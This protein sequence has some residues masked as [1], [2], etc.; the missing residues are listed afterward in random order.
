MDSLRQDARYAL[1]LLAN[2]PGF[3]AIAVLTLALGIGANTAIFSVVNAVLLGSLPYAEPDRLVFVAETTGS[4]PMPVSYPNFL[5]WR[6][7]QSALEKLAAYSADDFNLTGLDQAD[8]V[9]GELVSDDYFELLGVN[10]ILGRTF[11]EEENKTPGAAPVAMISH[12]F[13]QSRFGGDDNVLG[14]SLKLNDADFTIIGVAP[15]GFHGF[16]GIAEVWMPM[17]MRDALYPAT[18]RFGF[19]SARDIHWHRVLGRLSPGVT[20]ARAQSEMETIGARLANDFPQA[21]EGRGV[22]L[23]AA[24]E[25][26]V[27]NLRTPLLVLLAAVA[28]VLLIACTN[29]ANLFLARAAARSREMAIRLALGASRGRVIRQLLTETLIVA[30]LG[31]AA[32]LLLALW[33]VEFLV[34]ILPVSLPRFAT[35]S[36]VSIDPRVLAFTS[37]ISIITGV[38]M[39][40]IPALQAS[41]TGLNEA[42]KESGRSTGGPRRN[43]VRSVLVAAEIAL[44][45]MLMIGAGLMLRSFGR[46]LAVDPGFKPDHLVTLRFDAP[47]KK[48]QGEQRTTL[49]QRLVER[50]EAVPGVE[51][52][53]ATFLD[54]FV[55]GGINLEYT[56]EGRP[57]IDSA[58]RDTVYYHNISPNYFRTMGI[59]LT[60]GRDFTLND[61]LRSPQVMIVSASFARRYW[62]DADPLGMRVKFGPPESTAPWM[63]VAGVA[64]DMKFRTLRQDESAE[65]VIYTPLLQ[66]Q[67]VV[68]ISLIVRTKTEPSGMLATLRREVQAFDADIPIYSIAT[69]EDR[70]RGQTTETRSYALLLSLFGLVAA[71]LAAIGIYGVMAYS[72]A[73]RTH[74]IGVRVALG[75]QPRDVQRLVVGQ[76]MLIAMIGAA[77]GLIGAF[78]L[79]RLMSALLFNISATDP[80]T[81]V[82]I[83]LALVAVAL[84]ACLIPARRATKVDPM[85][86]LR[87]E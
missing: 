25:R 44:A 65:P 14:R 57:R 46:M 76:G 19:L 32:G 49:A 84:V 24:R 61:N 71:L 67:V 69:I 26:V 29:V 34:S 21:N 68:S 79:T 59:P 30:L 31:G 64:G 72:V 16:S 81:F 52:A 28:C 41:R 70:L 47:N 80:I 38:A 43:R 23:I 2:K 4:R 45:L 1:R 75:A 33:G 87:Y 35:V 40:L 86:A 66:N 48:Y 13:W 60:A 77:S 22:I 56:I 78:I 9:S 53:G 42:L 27:G 15:E 83:A 8:R 62:P 73:Q 5:D 3:A 10:A 7:H 51:S 11:L 6:A 85:V 39:G 82:V 20:L 58:E 37:V 18:A 17:M 12:G 36:A 54:P 55:W 74:E 50:I 63:T